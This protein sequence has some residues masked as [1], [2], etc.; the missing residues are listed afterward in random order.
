M[1]FTGAITGG[2]TTNE[3]VTI[4]IGRM[5]L[6]GQPKV[7]NLDGMVVL[8]QTFTVEYDA[9]DKEIQAVVVNDTSSYA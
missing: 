9:T 6:T 7:Y 3:S 1:T 4:K 5:V 2:G 8:N